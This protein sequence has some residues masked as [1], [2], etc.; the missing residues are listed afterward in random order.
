MPLTTLVPRIR[1]KNA[2]AWAP[3]GRSRWLWA[4]VAFLVAFLLRLALHQ[5]IGPRFPLVFFTLATILVHFIYGLGPALF[6]AL[7]AFPLANYAFVP[8]YFEWDLPDYQDL[9]LISYYL[10][11][12]ALLMVLIQYLRRAQYQSVLLAEIAESRQLMLLDSEA[13]RAALE[14]EIESRGY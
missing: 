9:L 6:I 4:F 7:A 14:A 1:L 12:T 10:C 3:R 8:P 2:R 5:F 13:D 11:T